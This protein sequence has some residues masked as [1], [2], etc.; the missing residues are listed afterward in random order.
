MGKA[1][2]VYISSQGER[3]LRKGGDSIIQCSMN[4]TSIFG[5]N[6]MIDQDRIHQPIR[7]ENWISISTSKKSETKKKYKDAFA[8]TTM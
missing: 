5:L 7:D 1:I 3:D 2:S 4:P 8:D 6:V